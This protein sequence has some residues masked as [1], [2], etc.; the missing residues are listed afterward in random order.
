MDRLEVNLLRTKLVSN[1]PIGDFIAR[2]GHK[3]TARV[4]TSTPMFKASELRRLMLALPLAFANLFTQDAI[5]ASRLAGYELSDPSV[6]I[7]HVLLAF[8]RWYGAA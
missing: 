3:V 6:S 4:D 2:V 5:D 7:C 8:G 1:E